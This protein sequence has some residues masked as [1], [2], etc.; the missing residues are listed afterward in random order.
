[1]SHEQFLDRLSHH[2]AMRI[3]DKAFSKQLQSHIKE[4]VILAHLNLDPAIKPLEK[5]YSPNKGPPPRDPGLH[6]QVPA[7]HDPHQAEKHHG[8]GEKDPV[9]GAFSHSGR[10]RS[11]GLIVIMQKSPT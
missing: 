2:L 5:L 11:R 3:Y 10:I 4:L 8:V 9:H 6:A 7:S 1:M